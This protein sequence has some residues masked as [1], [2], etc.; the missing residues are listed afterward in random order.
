MPNYRVFIH[1]TEVYKIDV[2][3]PDEES[4]RDIAMRQHETTYRSHDYYDCEVNDVEP[5]PDD[6]EVENN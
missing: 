5:L 4:A 2:A 6:A 1:E 3:A